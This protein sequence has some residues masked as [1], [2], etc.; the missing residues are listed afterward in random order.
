MTNTV[1]LQKCYEYNFEE[2]YKKLKNDMVVTLERLSKMSKE[3]LLNKRYERFRK[4]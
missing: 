1:A 3:E 2:V 4:F